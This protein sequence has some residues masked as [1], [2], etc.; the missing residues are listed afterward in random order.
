MSNL[1]LDSKDLHCNL[2]IYLFDKHEQEC[3]FIFPQDKF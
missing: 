1:N 3:T 2:G